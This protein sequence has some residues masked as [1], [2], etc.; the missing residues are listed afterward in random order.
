MNKN[1][2]WKRGVFKKVLIITSYWPPSGGSGVQRWLK[3]TKYLRDFNW[4]PVIYTPENPETPVEDYSLFRDI[5]EGITVLKKKIWEPYWFYKKFLGQKE[6]DKIQTGFLTEK[7]KPKLKEKISVR[8]RGNF[9]IPDARKFW[10][11]PSVKYLTTYLKKKPVDIIISTGPP[12][13][14]HLIA[15]GLKKRLNIPWL[16]DFRDPWTNIYYHGDLK[17]SRFSEKKHRKLELEVLKRADMVT[18]VSPTLGKNLSKIY[19]CNYHVITNG[20]DEDDFPINHNSQTDTKFSITHV[21]VLMKK[22][23]PENLWSI[24][25]ELTEVNEDF[26]ND[27][28]IKL[29]GKV[30]YSIINSIKKN[31]L[32]SY[33]TK[34]DY[35]PHEEIVKFQKQ[36]RVLLLLI[37]NTDNSKLIITGK[38]FEYL[39]SKRPV[40]AIGPTDG[41][42][43]EIINDM[44][45]GMISGFGDNNRLKNNIL[46]LYHDYKKGYFR[47]DTGDISKYSRKNLT[48]E[49][50]KLLN[51]LIK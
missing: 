19:N 15:L 26:K 49:L 2:P 51:E 32:F 46:A 21:G 8:I 48:E 29:V 10:I 12:H 35:L 43:A 22:S 16:A 18:V 42:A 7:K 17:L 5:P 14:M 47:F 36:A 9:F 27:L 20:F 41:D 31:N 11:R 44:K 28:E 3:F 1:H 37:P 38:L 45:A 50:V 33:L 40:L 30:D 6:E 23:N 24:L 34:I 4:E 25:R 13:S 39:A